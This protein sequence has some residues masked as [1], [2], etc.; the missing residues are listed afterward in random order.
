ME[1]SCID[2][3]E[4]RFGPLRGK[5]VLDLGGGP[6]HYSIAFAARGAE[7]TW[8]D[9][10]RRYL[11]MTRLKAA[12][13]GVVINLSLG[14][15]EDARRFAG[16]GFDLVFCRICWRYCRNDRDFARLFYSLLAPNGVGYIDT[17]IGIDSS[18]SRRQCLQY[19]LN[20]AFGWKV[21]HPNP[22]PGR[23]RLLFG[24]MGVKVVDVGC[25]AT[26]D[27][28]LIAGKTMARG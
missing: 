15:L 13:H 4:E 23:L 9:V 21:G 25:A 24:E 3:L 28:L 5:R 7:V 18:A 8:H 6:G 20:A 2:S 27:R 17:N 10:S 1:N 14:Y 26:N 11:E 12:Q 22:P 19:R 16:V